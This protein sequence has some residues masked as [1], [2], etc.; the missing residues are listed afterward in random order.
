MSQ[1]L[2]ILAP[3][4]DASAPAPAQPEFTGIEQVSEYVFSLRGE[5]PARDILVKLLLDAT[6]DADGRVHG[7]TLLLRAGALA[8]A[9]LVEWSSSVDL[10][11]VSDLKEAIESPDRVRAARKSIRAGG[12]CSNEW[13]ILSIARIANGGAV[14]AGSK[15]VCDPLK[16]WPSA[17]ETGAAVQ[18]RRPDVPPQL[19]PRELPSEAVA[20]LWKQTKQFLMSAGMTSNR[21]HLDIAAAGQRFLLMA[22]DTVPPIIAANLIIQSAII[23]SFL[24]PTEIGLRDRGTTP[25]A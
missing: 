16:C 11:R 22:K 4:R 23:A 13:G 19:R 2:Y 20:K 15:S 17:T 25:A 18:L 14:F 1:L 9:A 8:G 7:P 21:W 5:W 24:D 12:I 6:Q 10:A 3:R